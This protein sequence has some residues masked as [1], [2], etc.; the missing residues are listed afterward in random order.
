MYEDNSIIGCITMHSKPCMRIITVSAV[1]SQHFVAPPLA[2]SR[3]PSGDD[4]YLHRRR[5]RRDIMA[6]LQLNHDDFTS[7]EAGAC[8]LEYDAWNLVN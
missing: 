2:E 3:L 1:S 8:A 7:R 6:T 4:K 5:Y